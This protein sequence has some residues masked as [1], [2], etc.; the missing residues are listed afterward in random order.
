MTGSTQRY[1]KSLGSLASMKAIWPM[2]SVVVVVPFCPHPDRMTHDEVLAVS[3]L[4][5]SPWL[6]KLMTIDPR[7]GPPTASRMSHICRL[8]VIV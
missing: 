1:L 3:L 2:W 4:G 6:P 5:L 8:A 7:R